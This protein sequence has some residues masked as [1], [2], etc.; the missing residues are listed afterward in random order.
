MAKVKALFEDAEEQRLYEARLDIAWRYGLHLDDDGDEIENILF[1]EEQERKTLRR[2]RQTLE[3]SMSDIVERLRGP[4]I[5]SDPAV[6]DAMRIEAADSIEALRAELEQRKSD[7]SLMQ[8]RIDDLKAEN[9]RLIDRCA[10]IA[11]SL[12][13]VEWEDGDG[14]EYGSGYEYAAEEI[15]VAIRAMKDDET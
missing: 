8:R 4:Q 15:Y 12:M 2:T 14:G 6:Y 1:E 10:M 11:Y 9:E 3:R 13:K 7:D 5:W